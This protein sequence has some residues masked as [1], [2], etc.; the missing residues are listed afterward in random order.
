MKKRNK[1]FYKEKELIRLRMKNQELNDAIRNQGLVELEEPIHHGYNADWILRPDISRRTD[2]S[3]YQEALDACKGRIW[4]KTP[5]FRHKDKKTKRW[6]LHNPKMNPISKVTYDA[7]SPTAKK[8]YIEDT[9]NTRKY[10]KLGF[11]DIK[12]RCTLSYE[13]VVVVT[14][15]FITHRRE[16]DNVLYQ[17]E[18]ENEKMMYNVAGDD[19]PWGSDSN[20]SRFWR[21]HENTKEKLQAEREIVEIKKAYLSDDKY[22]DIQD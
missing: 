10:W 8:F 15:S 2:A 17:L 11:T 21:K 1:Y 6:V 12:Y 4:N 3:A 9:S 14:K 19:N 18:A 5:D 13:L 16:H 7:L 22:K 20:T